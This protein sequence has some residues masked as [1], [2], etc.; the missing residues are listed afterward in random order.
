[1]YDAVLILFHGFSFDNYYGSL[2]AD[3]KHQDFSLPPLTTRRKTRQG[4]FDIDRVESTQVVEEEPVSWYD[5]FFRQEPQV[6]KVET[7]DPPPPPQEQVEKSN[8]TKHGLF[9][10]SSPCPE[11]VS[12]WCG[13]RKLKVCHYNEEDEKFETLCVRKQIVT[14]HLM[15]HQ[16]DYCAECIDETTTE[17][18]DTPNPTT[19]APTPA[20]EEIFCGSSVSNNTTG[21]SP[22]DMPDCGTSN[23]YGGAIWYKFVGTG[24][25]TTFSTCGGLTDYDTKIRV[26]KADAANTCVAGNDDDDT[27]VACNDDDHNCGL[28]ST[29]E[30]T[31]EKDVEYKVLVQ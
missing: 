28:L 3:Q 22:V 16:L 14:N 18:T 12:I 26:Y 2:V 24:V 31:A 27:C 17:A 30:F 29:V 6:V 23:G 8:N 9:P 5:Q 25:S 4:I 21:L 19:P 7:T 15:D 11:E 1:M 10:S 20:P 13:Y